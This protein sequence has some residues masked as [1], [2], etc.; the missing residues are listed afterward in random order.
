VTIETKTTT[1]YSPSLRCT[2]TGRRGCWHL[3]M[4]RRRK[5]SSR[6]L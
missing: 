5:H 6:L 3:S 2:T 1:G 4:Y